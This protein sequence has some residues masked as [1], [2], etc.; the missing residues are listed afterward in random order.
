MFGRVM[1]STEEEGGTENGNKEKRTNRS[2]KK[3]TNKFKEKRECE[4]RQRMA[5]TTEFKRKQRCKK[6]KGRKEKVRK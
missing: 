3:R 4:Q 6:E 5:V 1:R 2:W